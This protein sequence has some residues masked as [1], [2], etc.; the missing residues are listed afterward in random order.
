[1]L[2]HKSLNFTLKR[3]EASQKAQYVKRY[4]SC[5]KSLGSDI[6]LLSGRCLNQLSTKLP[7]LLAYSA[8]IL[9]HFILIL[10]HWGVNDHNHVACT[11]CC[12]RPVRPVQSWR[13]LWWTGWARWSACPPS[14][15]TAPKTATAAASFRSG[16][17]SSVMPSG[18][19][20]AGLGVVSSPP[21][22]LHAILFVVFRNLIGTNF[23][24]QFV[25]V[26]WV[27][28]VERA[29]VELR[30]VERGFVSVVFDR[31]RRQR[32]RLCVC[33]PA[34]LRPSVDTRRPAL[35][36]TMPRSIA[37]WWRTALTRWKIALPRKT[38][39]YNLPEEKYILAVRTGICVSSF[40]C[41]D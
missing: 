9:Q 26:A 28:F 29:W 41:H 10:P 25:S 2:N 15:C 23:L 19:N 35:T 6:L 40:F 37:D 7:S 20:L 32:R 17:R 38:T 36:W 5:L 4:I 33:W 34:E 14:S 24:Y 27:G 8:Y 39:R 1:M 11:R 12:R 31:R 16:H 30:R 18:L 3:V 22:M 21:I 13:W